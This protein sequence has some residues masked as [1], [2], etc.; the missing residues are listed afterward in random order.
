MLSVKTAKSRLKRASYGDERG[1]CEMIF[2]Y[3]FL[4]QDMVTAKEL[5]L[6][7]DIPNDDPLKFAKKAASRSAPG[8]RLFSSG[9][10]TSW[11]GDFIWLICVNEEDGL[12][13]QVKQTHDGSKELEVHWREAIL[14]DIGYLKELLTRDPL[15]AVFQLRATA[16]LQDRVQLQL[17]ILDA[18]EEQSQG[19]RDSPDVSRDV[20]KTATRLREL[21]W[22]LLSRANQD[23]EQVVRQNLS[24]DFSLRRAPLVATNVSKM[25]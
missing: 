4:E 17:S 19:A 5:F 22:D 20:W 10:A 13:F 2:S 14:A 11:E 8:F 16:L 24:V 21:E 3:G 1:A 9:G 23:F 25:P 12:D 18:T 6:D 7:L 15:W